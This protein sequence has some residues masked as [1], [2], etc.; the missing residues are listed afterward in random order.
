[1]VWP[2]S[3]SKRKCLLYGTKQGLLEHILALID[4][5]GAKEVW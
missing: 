2:N 4:T 1:M 5:G 3:F